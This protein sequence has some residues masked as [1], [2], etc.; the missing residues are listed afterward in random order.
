MENRKRPILV[1]SI[2]RIAA[3]GCIFMFHFFALSGLPT[4]SLGTIGLAVFFFLA[5]W[6]GAH[7]KVTPNEWFVKRVKRILIPYWPV[8]F[9]VLLANRIVGYKETTVLK[10]ILVFF[11]FGLFVDNPVYVLSWFITMILMLDLSL[12]IFYRIKHMGLKALYLVLVYTVFMKV[13]PQN[14]SGALFFYGGFFINMMTRGKINA[15]LNPPLQAP[16][17]ERVNQKIYEIQN[18]TYSFFLVHAA[19][20]VSVFHFL[21]FNTVTLFFITVLMSILLAYIHNKALKRFV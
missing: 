16:W 14:I 4:R 20:L 18:Y 15:F 3:A 11:G 10:D 21:R 17:F 9:C 1:I 6:F 5:G 2:L 7:I 12:Y 19:V 8:I 13:T